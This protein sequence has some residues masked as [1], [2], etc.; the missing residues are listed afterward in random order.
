V[1][2]AQGDPRRRPDARDLHG[3]G[4]VVGGP[5]AE[6]AVDVA[7]PTHHLA[8]RQQGARLEPVQGDARHVRDARDL[9]GGVAAGGGPVAELAVVVPAPAHHLAVRQQ[10][11]R[12]EAAQGDDVGFS[13]SRDEKDEGEEQN[14]FCGECRHPSPGCAVRCAGV[15]GS[16][17]FFKGVR[18][19]FTGFH[20]YPRLWRR[21]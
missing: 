21:S 15:R 19:V 16:A 12:V 20:G 3:D 18:R 14:V 1:D 6:L 7:A 10:G 11:A 8:V 13:P 2:P 4:A 17:G 5:V 9:H